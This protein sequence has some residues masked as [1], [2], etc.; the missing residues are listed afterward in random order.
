VLGPHERLLMNG[1]TPSYLAEE[2]AG[3]PLVAV[4]EL[5]TSRQ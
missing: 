2:L 5:N 4:F 1:S 3:V